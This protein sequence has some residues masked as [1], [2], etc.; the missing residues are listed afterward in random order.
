MTKKEKNA[1]VLTQCIRMIADGLVMSKIRYCL[2]VY[3]AESLRLREIDPQALT[4]QRIQ[5]AQNDMLRVINHKR[6]RDHVRI[7]DMLDSSKFLSVNQM[8]AYALIVELWK[9]RQFNVPVLENL[10]ERS[11]N[12]ERTLRSD[13]LG[14]VSTNGH[15]TVALNCERLWNLSSDKFKKTNLLKVA[16]SE[17]KKLAKTLP[18]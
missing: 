2:P 18:I 15:D 5:R 1:D 6:R 17:A 10:L 8:T 14:K 3:A 11:R 7:I 13:T 4:L 16:K 9:A 12:D